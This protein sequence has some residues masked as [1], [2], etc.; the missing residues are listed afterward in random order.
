MVE[1][2]LRLD[3]ISFIKN[4]TING[5]QVVMAICIRCGSY[6]QRHDVMTAKIFYCKE[7]N[8]RHI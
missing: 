6:V 3:E 7:L 8:H 4:I 2:K 1:L 5:H